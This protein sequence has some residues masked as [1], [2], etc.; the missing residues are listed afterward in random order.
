MAN[1]QNDVSSPG[2]DALH[3]ALEQ[4]EAFL[5]ARMTKTRLEVVERARVASREKAFVFASSQSPEKYWRSV[6]PQQEPPAPR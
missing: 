1:A 5:E 4:Q 6:V 3:Y 2:R